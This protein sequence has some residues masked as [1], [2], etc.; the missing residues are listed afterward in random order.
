MIA[1][2]REV[3]LDSA[4]ARPATAPSQPQPRSG[5]G[6]EKTKRK[7]AYRKAAEIEREIG[8]LEIAVAELEEKLGQP[9]TWRDPVSAVNTQDR[10]RDLKIKLET[11]Y[12]HWETA[13]EANW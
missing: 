2:E 1:R 7:F 13:L 3:A 5:A 6:R 4:S 8:E 10:H 9:S 11:L 12:E